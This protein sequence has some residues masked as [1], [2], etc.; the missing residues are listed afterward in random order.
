LP[1]KQNKAIFPVFISEYSPVDNQNIAYACMPTRLDLNIVLIRCLQSH[2]QGKS[3]NL[4]IYP[5]PLENIN[6]YNEFITHATPTF[7]CPKDRHANLSYLITRFSA[8]GIDYSE[9]GITPIFIN[10][11]KIICDFISSDY[12]TVLPDMLTFQEWLDKNVQ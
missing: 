5:H 1:K 11:D 9:R 2:L 4:L 3:Y 8:M 6:L 10:L 7:I 12:F